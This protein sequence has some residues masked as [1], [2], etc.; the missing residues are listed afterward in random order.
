M[1]IQTLGENNAYTENPI[2]QHKFWLQPN[3]EPKAG[4]TFVIEEKTTAVF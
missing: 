3:V 2:R 1:Y 4:K